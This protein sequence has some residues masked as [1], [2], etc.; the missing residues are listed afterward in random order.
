[1]SNEIDANLYAEAV[2]IVTSTRR[3]SISSLQ[4]HLRIGYIR[5]A[6]LMERMEH[7]GVVSAARY[8]GERDVLAPR[9]ATEN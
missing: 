7:E 1:M 6:H 4:R 2:Q 5:A 3:A 8:N 9:S